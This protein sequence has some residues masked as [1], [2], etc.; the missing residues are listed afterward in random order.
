V[1]INCLPPDHPG[2]FCVS[3]LRLSALRRG[4]VSFETPVS[5]DGSAF[6]QLVLINHSKALHN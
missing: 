1:N 6:L 5:L 3:F 2:G 4:E